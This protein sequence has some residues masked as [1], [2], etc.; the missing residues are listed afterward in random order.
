MICMSTKKEAERSYIVYDYNKE[1]K[2]GLFEQNQAVDRALY[3]T[4]DNIRRTVDEARK[5]DP[6]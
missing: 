6:T 1:L 2:T 5:R 3:E 4:R